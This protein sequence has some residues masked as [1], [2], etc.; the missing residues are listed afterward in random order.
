MAP[1]PAKSISTAWVYLQDNYTVPR[2]SLRKA[3]AVRFV[4]SSAIRKIVAL[5]QLKIGAAFRIIAFST[6]DMEGDIA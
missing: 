3:Q 5:K 4:K 2:S 1:M 6:N